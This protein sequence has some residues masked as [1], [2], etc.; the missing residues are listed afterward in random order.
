MLSKAKQWIEK[1]IKHLETEFSRLQLWR[2]NPSIVEDIMVENYWSFQ[3]IKNVA[4]VSVMDAQTL[5]IKPW[6]KSMINKIAKAISESWVWL[7][8]QTMAD[9]IMIKMPLLTEER[10]KDMV[11]LAKKY[12]EE[13]KVWIRNA[14][15]ES[16]KDLKQAEDKKEISEDE[17]KDF[18]NQLQKMVDEWNKKIDE[19]WKKKEVDIMKV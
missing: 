17:S 4:W 7:N 3:P 8:P 11:K 13:A 9:S 5:F 6:D 16:N 15:A 14:R 1:A 2:A 12:S 18:T 19:L 10:R